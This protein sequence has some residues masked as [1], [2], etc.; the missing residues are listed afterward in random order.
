ME[1]MEAIRNRR[2]VRRYKHDLIPQEKLL[3]ILEAAR[4]AP[5]ANNIQPWHFIV[6]TNFENR[7][8][9]SASC[10][11]GQFLVDSPVV[12]VAC[13]DPVA[14]PRY[15]VIDTAIA[16]E[17]MVLA[18]TAEGLGT[19][20]IGSFNEEAIR[21]LLKIPDRLK[22]VALLSLGYPLEIP[23]PRPKKQLN[24]IVHYEY[25]GFRAFSPSK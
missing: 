6:V 7:S 21:K 24:E 15:Y 25:Y 2:S 10:T 11:F 5:S 18:A 14:S 22:I 12:I 4:L 1:V 8:K 19:C 13:G 20:W 23:S 16:L 3:N 9:I 17:H